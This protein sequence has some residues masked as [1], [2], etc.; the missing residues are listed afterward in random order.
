MLSA[1]RSLLQCLFPLFGL[2]VFNRIGS[3]LP[4]KNKTRIVVRFCSN[5]TFQCIEHERI[6]ILLLFCLEHLDS[7]PK[8]CIHMGKNCL[9]LDEICMCLTHSQYH[10]RKPTKLIFLLISFACGWNEITTNCSPKKKQKKKKK[11]R[12][13]SIHTE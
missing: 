2:Y 3:P 12:L 1:R 10:Q 5:Q 11:K 13:D 8:Q 7:T 6:Y 4:T 9:I